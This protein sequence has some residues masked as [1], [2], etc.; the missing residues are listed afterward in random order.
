MLTAA[1]QSPGSVFTVRLAGQMMFGLMESLSVIL[2]V[3]V[4]KFCCIISHG[5][6]H[7]DHSGVT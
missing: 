1:V 3:Q 7:R 2:N 5:N 6:G 4:V